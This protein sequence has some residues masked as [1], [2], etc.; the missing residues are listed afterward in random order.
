M[1]E[2]REFGYAPAASTLDANAPCPRIEGKPMDIDT[3]HIL[4]KFL[5]DPTRMRLN[6][7]RVWPVR[8]ANQADLAGE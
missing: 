1:L 6:K 3:Y 4:V 7:L 5:F 8:Y 2:L